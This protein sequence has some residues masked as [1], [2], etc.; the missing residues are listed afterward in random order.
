[1]NFVVLI[2]HATFY[3][4]KGKQLGVE[5]L[6]GVEAEFIIL[7]STDPISAVNDASWSDS[8]GMLSGS[9]AE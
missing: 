2:V 3:T 7:K 1:M 8:R 4:S 9:V 5:F 6:V